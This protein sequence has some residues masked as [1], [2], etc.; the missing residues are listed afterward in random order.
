[1]RPYLSWLAAIIAFVVYALTTCRGI[2][3]GDSAEFALALKTLGI[4]HPPGYP[5]F[6]LLGS[7][8]VQAFSFLRP[9]FAGAIFSSVVAA[10]AVGVIC[11]I[12]RKYLGEIAA[13]G[14]ALVWAFTPIFWA[15]TNGVEVYTLNVL[16]IGLTYLSVE[17]ESTVKWPLTVYFFGLCLCNH[18]SA[19]A[20][21]PVIVYRF[22]AEKEYKNFRR[23]PFYLSLLMIAGSM[24]FYLLFRSLNNPV[25]DWG[26]PENLRAL[27]QHMTLKQY[28]GWVSHSWENLV[29]SLKLYAR[30]IIDCW[31]WVG[32]LLIISGTVIGL[33]RVRVRTIS[34]LLMLFAALFMAA[35]HQAVNH[36]PFFLPPLLASLFLIANNF[37]LLRAGIFKSR[38]VAITTICAAILLLFA[39]YE[40][41]D[42]SDSVLYEDYSQKLLD[43]APQNSIL[44]VA[45]DINSFGTLY[46]HYG[47]KYRP[48]LEVYDRSIRK[49]VMCERASSLVGTQVDDLLLARQVLLERE[50]KRKL[51]AKSHYQN[52][53][54]WWKDL[55]SLHS[56]GLLY[57]T[58]EPHQEPAPIPD[59]A[60]TLDD[61]DLMLRQLLVNLDLIRGEQFLLSQPSDSLAALSEFKS[62]LGRYDVE[63]RGLLLNQLGIFLRKAGFGDLALEAY[64]RALE[65]PILTSTQRKEILFN[66]SNVFK[67]RGNLAVLHSDYPAAA[68]AFERAVE[69]DAGNPRLLLNLGLVY[70]Q[71]L[72]DRDKALRYLSHYLEIEPNDTRV[73]NLVNSLR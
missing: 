48:D 67:D 64:R 30:T 37:D 69:Y 34:A 70:A 27:W 51:F 22:V 57:D 36:E 53:T 49:R 56:F 15:E 1:M 50:P 5:L 10:G 54:D 71:H 58:K 4:A 18:P 28:S 25:D 62:A 17:S 6:T 42:R 7:L 23:L 38:V 32:A 43:A 47:E 72:N 33:L 65:K 9:I 2:W 16:L 21:A 3:I 73:Q 68:A 39:N 61:G 45:G 11:L 40:K 35:F 19:I 13:F 41:N 44:F 66:I 14:L 26:N 55:D 12:L 60:T 63:P 52:E 59:Y 46:L 29:F 31:T 24:Y 8:F 20:L